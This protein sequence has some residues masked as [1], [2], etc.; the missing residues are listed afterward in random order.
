MLCVCELLTCEI[1]AVEMK[2][3]IRIKTSRGLSFFGRS[4]SFLPFVGFVKH[5]HTRTLMDTPGALAGDFLCLPVY[6]C[7]CLLRLFF[8]S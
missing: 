7:V 4:C 5:I 6:V 3:N 8:L 1:L 2:K